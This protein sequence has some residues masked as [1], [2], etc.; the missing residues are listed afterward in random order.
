M[1]VGIQNKEGRLILVWNDGKR[2]TMAIGMPDTLPGKALAEKTKAE[3]EWDWHIKQYDP[4][5]LKYKPRTVGSNATEISAPELFDRFTKFQAKDKKL[6]ESSIETRYQPLKRMLEKHLNIPA[7][8]IGRRQVERFADVCESV[9][10]CRSIT[11]GREGKTK[12]KRERVVNLS[13]AII[14]ML[15]ARKASQQPQPN[16]LV[17][18]TPSGLPIND[19]NFC[20]RAWKT[21]VKVAGVDYRRPY[22]CRKTAASHALRNTRDYVSV[23]KAL[24]HSPRVLLDTYADVIESRSVINTLEQIQGAFVRFKNDRIASGDYPRRWSGAV[25]VRLRP[26]S[27]R[28]RQV[29]DQSPPRLDFKGAVQMASCICARKSINRLE[30]EPALK[31]AVIAGLAAVHTGENLGQYLADKGFLNKNGGAYEGAS[32]SRFRLAIKYLNGEGQTT[33]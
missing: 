5:L 21:V 17:F 18:S 13:P 32:N 22:T 16:D 7:N 33:P 20:R 2:R 26:D 29:K 27:R 10:I 14:A 28:H 6:S 30:R 25:L 31:S 12:T 9:H 3:I 19:K 15:K 23:A 8:D 24:G 1:K 4:T 11:R